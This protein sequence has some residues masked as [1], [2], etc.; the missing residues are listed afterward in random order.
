MR[1]VRTRRR[2]GPCVEALHR[3]APARGGGGEARRGG[4]I[5]GFLAARDAGRRSST[6]SRLRLGALGE[7]QGEHFKR[8]TS[9][10]AGS[11]ASSAR[12]D[13]PP[14]GVCRP[15]P[16]G[17]SFC[18]MRSSLQRGCVCEAS[19]CSSATAP[20]TNAT[21][22]PSPSIHQPADVEGADHFSAM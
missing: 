10:R 15:R 5:L 19:S 4:M 22:C 11:G 2:R 7:R 9:L 8:C 18:S 17:A 12:S 20:A 13:A 1:A 16:S 21:G 14:T 3:S 6:V